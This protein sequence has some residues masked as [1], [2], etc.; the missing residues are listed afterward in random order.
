MPRYLSVSLLIGGAVSLVVVAL[1]YGGFFTGLV[2]TLERYY[3]DLNPVDGAELARVRW[4]EVPVIILASCGVAWGVIDVTRTHEKIIVA[5]TVALVVAGLSP[6]LA[7]YDRLYDLFSCLS[8]VALATVAAF[9][10]SKTEKGM[11]KRVLEEVIGSRVSVETFTE[12]LEAPSA[13]DF[14]GANRAVT[15]LT[16]RLF[17]HADLREKLE[18]AELMKMSGLFV[19]SVSG[20]LISKGA[21]LDE[22]SPELVRVT[23]GM[24]T[25]IEDHAQRACRAAIELRGRLR[26]LNYE[27]ESRWYQPLHCGVGI[28]SGRMTV[29]IYGYAPEPLFSGIGAETDYSRRLAHA[30]LRYGSDILVGPETF[31]L[32][33]DLFEVRP[34]EMFYDPAANSMTEIYQLLAAREDYSD[35]ERAKRDLFWQGIIH[36]RE[37]NPEAALDCFSRSRTQGV[38]DRPL[39]FYIGVAQDGL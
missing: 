9:A 14:E 23:F 36:L 11:R 24:L 17:N 10:Y 18:P 4:I 30:N 2:S 3:T 15:V 35:E 19:R 6:T 1:S 31:R 25:P 26:N 28:G 8:A 22:S 37:Q 21:F 12:L 38:D 33:H 29:G 34:M 32:V 39:A 16:C 13:P 7:V 20:F 27:C 5:L